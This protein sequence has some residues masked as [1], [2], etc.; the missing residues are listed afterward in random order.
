MKIEK[1]ADLLKRLEAETREQARRYLYKT[2][3]CGAWIVFEEDG[4]R[5]GSIIEGC[6][7]DAQTHT[8]KYPFTELDLDV[9]I[10]TIE[11]EVDV[12]WKLANRRGA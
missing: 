4:I 1:E 2:T 10:R 5:I 3:E 9:A 7:F 12:Y 8:L 11:D 6:D